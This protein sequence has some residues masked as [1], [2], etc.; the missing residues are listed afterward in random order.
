MGQ[1]SLLREGVVVSSSDSI[2]NLLL[3]ILYENAIKDWLIKDNQ[4]NLIITR[5]K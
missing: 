1:Y 4:S 5:R 3:Q 2:Y